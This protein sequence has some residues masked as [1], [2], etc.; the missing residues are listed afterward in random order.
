MEN[1]VYE[2]IML[3]AWLHDIGKFAQRAGMEP[4]CAKDMEGQFCKLQKDDWYSHQH[5]LYTEGFLRTHINVLPDDMNQ[6]RVIGLAASHHNPSSYYEWLIAYGDRL[7]SGADRRDVLLEK[8][9]ETPARF[10]EKPLTHLVSTLHLKDSS[11]AKPAYTP[12]K[13]LEHDAILATE[14]SKV[15]KEQYRHLWDQFEQDFLALKGLKYPEF[16]LALDTLLERY[17]WCIPSATNDDADISL[18]Q[19]SKTT[20]ACAGTLYR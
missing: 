7:S 11:Q 15:S 19:H 1:P 6:D 4:Y 2:E 14:K 9:D 13:A 18:Y 17:L 8:N 16:M 5:V 20:A 10:Y 12:L 3:A